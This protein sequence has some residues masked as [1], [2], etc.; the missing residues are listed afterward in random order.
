MPILISLCL[1]LAFHKV[2]GQDLSNIR[3]QKPLKINGTFGS[4]FSFY[5][6][7]ERYNSRDPFSWNVYASLTPTIYGISL[8]FSYTITQYSSSYSQ[9]FV[10]MGISPSYKWITLHAGYR[11]ITLSPLI[12]DGQ[13]FL[14]GGV[15]LK[16]G[17]F[18]SSAFYG[19]LNKAITEDTTIDRR[20]QPQYKRVGYGANIG[21]E[22]KGQKI[23]L[24][25]F[26]A[27]DDKNSIQ[28]LDSANGLRPQENVALGFL[29]NFVFFKKLTFDGDIAASLLNRSLFYESL[30]NVEGVKIPGIVN[31]ISPI[32][33]A[34]VFGYSGRSKLSL[35]L[36]KFNMTLGYNRIQPDYSSLG[37]PYTVNDVETVNAQIGVNLLK[38]KL[39][40]NTYAFTQHN[41][42]AKSLSTE[43]NSKSINFNANAIVNKHIN[44]FFNANAVNVLQKDGLLKLTD[45]T[46]MN[47]LMLNFSLSPNYNFVKNQKSHNVNISINYTDLIDR[48]PATK[49]F[50]TG[51]N[52]NIGSFYSVQF[53]KQYFGINAGLNFSTYGQLN[54]VYNSLGINAGGNMQFLKEHNLNVAGNFGYYLNSS[55]NG[56]A[57]NNFSFSLNS[58]MTHKKHSFGCF[59]N[60]IITPPVILNPLDKINRVPIAVNTRNFTAGINY[61]YRF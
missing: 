47:Q 39:N 33:Y 36:S 34:S 46:R 55:T 54:Y 28:L 51:N 14:G 45:S 26:H 57:A 41:N 12:F 18:R 8:P 48:N 6:S 4:G 30:D 38:G 13:S 3:S 2:A 22:K 11:S 29:W 35:R 9:P 59:A 43:I 20:L 42:L 53:T 31:M 25:Y 24:T 49:E 32:S 17:I 60:Y 21:I 50:T 16:P 56:T 1:I 23:A 61:N 37:T 27:K 15:E 7:N 44:L 10:Q 40:F 52:I 58:N 5:N 19:R